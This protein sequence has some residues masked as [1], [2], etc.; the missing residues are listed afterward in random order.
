MGCFMLSRAPAAVSRELAK[1][2][3]ELMVL[4]VPNH[5]KIN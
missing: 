2:L 5:V 4:I 1:V 3:I